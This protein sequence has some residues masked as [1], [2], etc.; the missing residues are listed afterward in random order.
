MLLLLL[1]GLHILDTDL[2]DAPRYRA[3]NSD[4]NDAMDEGREFVLPESSYKCQFHCPC[5]C[6]YEWRQLSLEVAIDFVAFSLR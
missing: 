2:H 4:C 1:E 6:A 5:K 3:F